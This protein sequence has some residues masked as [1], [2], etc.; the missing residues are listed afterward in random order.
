MHEG[1]ILGIS[2]PSETRPANVGAVGEVLQGVLKTAELLEHGRAVNAG[3][4][5]GRRNGRRHL[6]ASM[7]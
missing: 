2:D 4:E 3:P 6:D 1:Y 7:S 5:G